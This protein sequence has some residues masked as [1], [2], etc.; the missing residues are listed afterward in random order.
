MPLEL[1]G[2]APAGD[3]LLVLPPFASIDRPSY[4]LHL[5]QA[6]AA[7][8]GCAASVLYANIHFAKRI[9]EGF[10][11]ELCHS[12]VGKLNGE[13]VFADAAFG[14]DGRAFAASDLPLLA[15]EN[16]IDD[17]A[18]IAA[19]WIDDLAQAIA[20]L[21]YK[22]VGCNAMFEQTTATI[23]LFRRLKALRPDMTLIVGGALCEGPMARGMLSLSEA[24]DYVFSGE[25][26]ETFID[27]L[28]C[29]RRGERPA[30]RILD[31]APCRDLEALPR[32]DYADYFAQLTAVHPDS[33]FI[34]AN[35]IWLP[36]EGSRGCWWGQKHHCTFCGLNGSGMVYRQ[37]SAQ[38]V[39]DD[40]ADF[41]ARYPAR[42]V[43][44]LDNIMPHR[45]FAD[46]LPTL[47]ARKLPLDI[48]FEQK[49]NLTFRRLR[50]LREAGVNV[51][52]PGIE[53]LAD[54]LLERMKKG[55]K[56]RQNIALLR[57][58]RALDMVVNWN[59]LYGFPGDEEADYRQTLA[60]VP[61]LTHLNPPSGFS[62]RSIDRFS[63]YHEAAAA[64]GIE[65]V[66]PMP[67]Y[68]DVYPADADLGAL[69]YH[70]VGDYETAARRAPDL[71][72]A[73][74]AAVEDWRAAWFS[75]NAVPPTLAV[76]PVAADTFAI[77]DTR[78]VAVKRVHLIDGLRARA[79]LAESA[80][81][82]AAALWAIENRL[83]VRLG[84]IVVPLA[85]TDAASFADMFDARAEARQSE[86]AA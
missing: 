26:E 54:P 75:E 23:A 29:S 70:F 58:A 19:Q 47:Q 21:D 14:G 81:D 9:G 11:T 42:R 43:M 52:Q 72:D 10:Y 79:A 31:G 51:I 63:P 66:R 61:L 82:D 3:I 77:V 8:E 76:S 59:L 73:V 78:P 25:S 45:F 38:R 41:A 34:A 28:R 65:S 53:A 27:F 86:L 68:A 36:Y 32:V 69:A 67:A 33:Q 57:F 83:A 1:S 4:A 12:P 74:T 7:R 80:P 16:G 55:V 35:E 17:L 39:Y 20:R 30:A 18:A 6:L 62:A 56:A 13:R 22:I 2:L 37:R 60:L 85:T 5:L 15:K 46:L 44:M 64:F 24:I 50:L 48:F 84:D 49:A 40:L 71:I